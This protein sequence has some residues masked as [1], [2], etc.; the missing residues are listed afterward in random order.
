M[1]GELIL[2]VN[3]EEVG[4]QNVVLDFGIVFIGKKNSRD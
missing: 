3:L 2:D 1:C 4:I